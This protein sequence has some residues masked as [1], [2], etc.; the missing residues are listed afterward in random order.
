M[1][2]KITAKNDN[3]VRN[4]KPLTGKAVYRIDGLSLDND[5]LV[6][7]ETIFH[8]ANGY[9][10]VRSCFEEDYPEGYGSIRGSY[11]NGFYDYVEMKQ[12]EKLY[13]LVEEKQTILNVADSQTI[14]LRLGGETF[15]MFEGTVLE[16]SRLLDMDEGYTERRVL[17][18]SPAGREA[19]ISIRRMAS[20]TQ[21]SLFTID[22]R[23]RSLNFDDEVVIESCHT[24][25]V[26]NYSNPDDPRVA[27]DSH[28]HLLPAGAW[29]SGD[30]SFLLSRTSRSGLEVCTGV[31]N[32]LKPDNGGTSAG[33][34]SRLDGHGAVCTISTNIKRGEEIRLVKYTVFCDSIRCGDLRACAEAEMAKALSKPIEKH[35][36]EQ[37]LYLRNYWEHSLLEI[38]GDEELDIAVRYNLY[39]LIQS[40]GKDRYGNIAAKGLSGEG[41]EGHYFW[42]TEMYIQ[43]FFTL[44]NPLI[45]KSLIEY[46]YRILDEAR[47]NARL[48]GHKKGALYPWRTIM[49][50]EC[51]GYFP[52]GTAQYHINGDIAHSIVAYYLATGDFELI[53]EKGAEIVFETARLWIDTGNYFKGFFCINEVT[54]PDEYTCLVD[55][56]Y[57]TNACAQYNL[58][59]A[60]RFY[61]MLEAAGRLDGV[62]AKTGLATDEIAE[63]EK[64]AQNMYLPYDEELKINPQD[65]S[66][67]R[68][69][70]WDLKN[71]PKDDFPLLL[72]YHPLYLYRH[73]V[74][75]QADTVLAHF[76][77]EDA[78]SIETVRNSFEYYE[79]VTT[80]DSSLSTCIFS[81]VASKLGLTEKAYQYF[82]DSAKL[83]LFDTHRNTRDGIHTA[84][85]GG[86]YMAIVYG[87]GG[88]RLK[89]TGICF[90]PTLP[91][92]W[93]GYRFRVF[94]RNSQIGVEVRKGESTFTL[95]N[96]EPQDIYV[97]G[98]KFVLADRLVFSK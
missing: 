41:Y 21:P 23:V 86:T 97:Y 93:T 35:Y 6:L 40:V 15:S 79:S 20:F 33:M 17:W 34:D 70:K 11:I 55:N 48:L 94:Y 64:A 76:V 53:A 31:R 73:Q 45:S 74:C 10:G 28:R 29:L 22:Y 13:G 75:K 91:S 49:G 80:H 96:G 44:T 65:D 25:D 54:G 12:A 50:R 16:S 85:M 60:V 51:S 46:R 42:D 1:D 38:D 90:A 7:N 63:F 78:Q 98:E 30:T 4:K 24:G 32:V 95:L 66:F 83:D 87:F 9:I 71:T 14:R 61:R 82:G 58:Q 27:R 72:H 37:R 57:Y 18:R 68:K 81:I 47:R 43:P 36:E 19:E 5:D 26:M 2:N 3:N 88:L 69:K 59:W 39:Q 89:E 67:L 52:A 56:N 62:V 92:A 8:N 77:F 84:N